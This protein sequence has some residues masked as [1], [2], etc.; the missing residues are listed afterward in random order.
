MIRVARERVVKRTSNGCHLCTWRKVLVSQAVTVFCRTKIRLGGRT[1]ADRRG[2]MG[3]RSK[4]SSN[5]PVRAR[6]P[7]GFGSRGQPSAGADGTDRDGAG[8]VNCDRRGSRA[9]EE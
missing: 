5:E 1:D 6:D 9:A 4:V 7:G 3:R 8:S 2:A